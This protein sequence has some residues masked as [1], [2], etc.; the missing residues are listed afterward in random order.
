[1]KVIRENK[2]Q[3]VLTYIKSFQQKEG[4]SP[5]FRQIA[6]FVGFSSISTAQ[7]YVKILKDRGII[8]Q[9]SNGRIVIPNRLTM[10]KTIIAPLVGNIACGT[11][12]LAEQNIEN[13]YRLPVSIFGNEPVMML[14]ACGDS[15]I[16]A[17]IYNGDLII[18]KICNTAENGDIVVAL[19]EDSATVKRFY[20]EKDHYVL[21]AENPKYKDIV[22]KHVEIQGVVK[23][24]IHYV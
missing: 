5:S 3:E 12:I 23:Q 7:K 21:H 15:M 13:L 14:N 8:E 9:N 4:R 11:P 10:G 18:A 22:L 2:V 24:T 19:I 1:M 6:K 17:G 16:G 20:K